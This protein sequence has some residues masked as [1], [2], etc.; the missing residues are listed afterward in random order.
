MS[1]FVLLLAD[2]KPDYPEFFKY[3][4][5][6][7]TGKPKLEIIK[8]IFK[9]HELSSKQFRGIGTYRGVEACLSVFIWQINS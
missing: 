8:E 7:N 9:G 3:P 6:N 2:F 5:P 4:T 1:Y